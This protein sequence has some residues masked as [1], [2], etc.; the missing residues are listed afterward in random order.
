MPKH[1]NATGR[2]VSKQSAPIF[3]VMPGLDPV[4]TGCGT[5]GRGSPLFVVMPGL[6]P[7][8]HSGP[9]CAGL[10]RYGMGCRV[11]PGN[12]DMTVVA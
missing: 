3:V 4:H 8:I 2:G 6:D 10:G 7:G 12:D 11:K 9:V 1:G 5:E